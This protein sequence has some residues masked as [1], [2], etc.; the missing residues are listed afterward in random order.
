MRVHPVLGQVHLPVEHHLTL[1]T[2]ED[3]EVKIMDSHV[4]LLQW[5]QV[6]PCTDIAAGERGWGTVDI[7]HGINS[8]VNLQIPNTLTIILSQSNH[9]SRWEEDIPKIKIILPAVHS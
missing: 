9:K 4:L 5:G 3:R 7:A 6:K 2:Q 8:E 1:L